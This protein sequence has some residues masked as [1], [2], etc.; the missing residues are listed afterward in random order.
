M[1]VDL[2]VYVCVNLHIQVVGHDLERGSWEVE[3]TTKEGDRIHVRGLTEERKRIGW[4]EDHGER[5]R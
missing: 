1:S 3:E 5:S 4:E 2:R